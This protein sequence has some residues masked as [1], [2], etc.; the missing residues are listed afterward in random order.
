MTSMSKSD[1]P[2]LLSGAKVSKFKG[3]GSHEFM[4]WLSEWKKYLV[5][6][7]G[8]HRI[9]LEGL[10]SQGKSHR[11]ESTDFKV[12][13]IEFFMNFWNTNILSEKSEEIKIVK[14]LISQEFPWIWGYYSQKQITL[15][16]TMMDSI[17]I[18]AP[19]WEDTRYALKVLLESTGVVTDLPFPKLFVGQTQ[20]ELNAR[21]AHTATLTNML[22]GTDPDAAAEANQAL[23]AEALSICEYE[24]H[25]KT[26]RVL[27]TDAI[28]ANAAIVEQR[29]MNRQFKNDDEL[30]ADQKLVIAKKAECKHFA[31]YVKVKLGTRWA[32][33]DK[34]LREAH[35]ASE[36][37]ANKANEQ[38]QRCL[39]A[40]A[41][42][43][44]IK[45][46]PDAEEALKRKDYHRCFLAVDNY[47]MRS[48]GQDVGR[49]RKE[50]ESF[51]LQ[52]G[53][54]LNS[55]LELMR[56]SIERWLNIEF[57]EQKSLQLSATA[58]S[59]DPTVNHGA[60]IFIL[61]HPEVAFDNSLDLTDAEILAKGEPSI[62][63]LSEAK[64]FTLYAN[65]VKSSP[66]F[67]DIVSTMHAADPST[68]TVRSLLQSL[69][70]YEL[71]TS[72]KD[73]L[74][75][76][77]SQNPNYK[78][79]IKSFLALV[80]GTDEDLPHSDSKEKKSVHFTFKDETSHGKSSKGRTTK[81]PKNKSE[82]EDGD[83]PY[84]KNHPKTSTHWTWDCFKTIAE[85]K[86]A[87]K[88]P[89]QKSWQKQSSQNTSSA[90]KGCTWCFNDEAL[91]GK[92]L[93]HFTK[94]C[95]LDPKNKKNQKDT[96]SA[97][98][99]SKTSNLHLKD[100]IRDVLNEPAEKKPKANKKRNRKDKSESES[101]SESD[102]SS[103]D[104]HPRIGPMK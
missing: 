8:I 89:Q 85:A 49:F 61:N 1:S 14:D 88:A 21:I 31:K 57:M 28:K 44:D 68:R 83:I 24:L 29:L 20:A 63:L 71:S 42:L 64:R 70:N 5:Y 33:Y 80:H 19:D 103:N 43:G 39:D 6:Y 98:K 101:D 93:T 22:N 40:M 36:K 47:Y 62:V 38:S 54:D 67:K 75:K 23:V 46:I 77:R 11:E 7:H 104:I 53:Q 82:V 87:A 58:S 45:H 86:A 17:P 50:A 81:Y 92:S 59:A 73:D 76:E 65:S 3:S 78:K 37:R 96:S 27:I 99:S 55:H 100:A 34:E 95:R 30:E 69:R 35:F 84:C 26:K 90:V 60:S 94:D 18:E 10:D 51:R 4:L 2:S 79:D 102:H 66:R 25:D 91:R 97:A 9:I 16:S 41:L 52:P 72:G 12:D 48:G 74:E 13:E 15:Q 32:I 56:S